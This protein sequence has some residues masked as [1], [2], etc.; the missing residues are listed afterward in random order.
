MARNVVYD[1]PLVRQAYREEL[2]ASGAPGLIAPAQR[3][4]ARTA[5][6]RKAAAIPDENATASKKAT[7]GYLSR[8]AKYVPAETIAI[9]ALLFA[10]FDPTGSAVW[11]WLVAGAVGNVVYLLSLAVIGD[12]DKRPRA[13]FYVLSAVA[14]VMWAIA[15]LEVVAAEFGIEGDKMEGQQGAIL[16]AAAFFIPALDVV[17]EEI[18]SRIGSG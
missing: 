18:S 9:V 10:Q 15:T 2:D 3:R 11:W 6:K 16:A 4:T 8:I 5:A 1:S 12:D 13:L 14:F 17:L 7:D